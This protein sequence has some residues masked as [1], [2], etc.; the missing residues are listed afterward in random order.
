M[1][2]EPDSQP[3]MISMKFDL[4]DLFTRTKG[5][6]EAPKTYTDKITAKHI[7]AICQ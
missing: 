4:F 7:Y 1:S 3:H 2:G 5:V 6:L